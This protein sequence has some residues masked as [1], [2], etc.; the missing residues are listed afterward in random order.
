M[1]LV[2]SAAPFV[3]GVALPV[4]LLVT[5]YL[6]T[7]S[8]VDLF[9]G[10]FVTPRGRLTGKGYYASPAPVALVFAVPV[11]LVLF[12][13]RSKS[14]T[15]R[16][17]DI[18]AAAGLTALLL[19][20]IVFA[21]YMPIWWMT[22]ALLPVGIIVGVILLAR[23]ESSGPPKPSG[24]RSTCCSRWRPS[25][26]S[27]SFRTPHRRTS[28]SSRHWPSSPGWRCSAPVSAWAGHPR[29]PRRRP[30]D[31]DRARIRP[32]PRRAVLYR[33]AAAQGEPAGCDPRPRRAWI[34]VRP[35][36]KAVYSR[37]SALIDAHARGS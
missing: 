18:A 30:G 7:G 33:T 23:G 36:D 15:A 20:S 5:P 29:L 37:T 10:L 26:A 28:A 27:C 9:T 22:T 12:A 34:R 24:C 31:H 11:V 4:V 16:T 32:Q 13:V 2:G 35:A 25:S 19:V 1:L 3:A 6:V 17:V 14:R 8:L 21:D